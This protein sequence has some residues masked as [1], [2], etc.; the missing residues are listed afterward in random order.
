MTNTAQ[1]NWPEINVLGTEC[2]QR[3]VFSSA[4]KKQVGL[5]PRNYRL[6]HAIQNP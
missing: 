6:Q 5:S 4:F 1:Q 2:N 3:L